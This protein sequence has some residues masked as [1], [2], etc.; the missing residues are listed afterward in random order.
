[1]TT[2]STGP[3]DVVPAPSRPPAPPHTGTVASRVL[4]ALA[5]ASIVLAVLYGLV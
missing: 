4:G 2:P 5:L 1:M 3:A